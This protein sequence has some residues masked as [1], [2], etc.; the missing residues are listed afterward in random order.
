MKFLSVSCAIIKVNIFI[1]KPF[2]QVDT[3]IK[4]LRKICFAVRLMIYFI[5]YN[6]Q[7]KIL[8]L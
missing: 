8:S 6:A 5:V 1:S 4:S 3:L 7:M 2:Q